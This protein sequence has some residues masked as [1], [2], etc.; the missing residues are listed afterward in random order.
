MTG[1]YNNQLMNGSSL[2]P[3]NTALL[4]A[5]VQQGHSNVTS[6]PSTSLS[7]IANKVNL[8]NGTVKAATPVGIS[9]MTTVPTSGAPAQVTLPVQQGMQ[10]MTMRPQA[11]VMQPQQVRSLTPRMILNPQVLQNAVRTGTPG[12]SLF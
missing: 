11:G 8:I 2:Q 9:T 7:R 4:E 12:V 1:A 10:L 6:V 5:I 3:G